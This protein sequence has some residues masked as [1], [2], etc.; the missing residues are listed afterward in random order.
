MIQLAIQDTSQASPL[1]TELLFVNADV[2]ESEILLADL[3]SW[4]EVIHLPGNCNGI[5]RITEVLA[6]HTGVAA[7]H[8]LG[9]GEKGQIE[10]GCTTLSLSSL[11]AACADISTWGRSLA[12]GAD[13]LFYGCDVGGSADGATLIAQL[14]YLTGANVAASTDLTGA[15]ALGG[16]WT[17]GVQT[18][19]IETVLPFSTAATAAW[20]HTLNHFRYGTMSWEPIA[21]SPN[22]VVIKGQVDWTND[23]GH[24]PLSTPIG[25]VVA[26]RLTLNFGDGTS[27]SVAVRVLSRDAVTDDVLTEFVS[28]LDGDGIIGASEVGIRHNYAATGN[29]EVFWGSAAREAARGQNSSTWQQDMRID[30]N[31]AGNQSPVVATPA[32]VQVVD[33]TTFT[34]QIAASDPDGNPLRFRYGTQDEFYNNN[35]ATEATRPT[36][37]TLSASGLITWDVHNTVL[38]TAT[39]DR[40]Q[41][42]IMAEDLDANGN[43]K[44]TV[45]VDFVLQIVQAG[46]QPPTFTQLPSGPQLATPG[47]TSTFT[48]EMDDPDSTEA[49]IITVL[50]P[51][52]TN[53]AVFQ[54]VSSVSPDGKTTLTISFTPT[55]DLGGNSYVVNIRGRDGTGLTTDQ[56]ITLTV[57]DTTPPSVSSSLTLAV[58]T[59]SGVIGDGTTNIATPTLVGTATAGNTVTLSDDTDGMPIVVGTAVADQT[60]HWSYT[61]TLPVADGTY[62][63]VATETLADGTVL[64]S[65]SPFALTIDT[66]A[67]A[68]P[69]LALAAASDSG[70]LGDDITNVTTPTISGPGEA[71]DTVTLFDGTT[72]VGAGI[73]GQ[74]GTWAITSGVLVPGA[75][76]FTA[77][78]SDVAGNGSTFSAALSVTIDTAPPATVSS[79]ALS[80]ATDSGTLGDRIT[81]VTTP[82]ITGSGGAGDTVTLYDNGTSIGTATVGAN[83]TWSVT[84][85]TLAGGV[86]TLTATETDYVGNVS[87]ASV[88]LGL[89]IDTAVPAAPTGLTLAPASD[90][91]ISGDDVTSML[92][93]TITG[94]AEGGST[95]VLSDAN[96]TLGTAVAG[97][98]GGWSIASS[99]LTAGVH[100]L[101]ATAADAA[102]NTSVVSAQLAL[103]VDVPSSPF[104]LALSAATDTGTLGDGITKNTKPTLTGS[105]DPN[106]TVTIT[107]TS[108]IASIVVGAV[109]ANASGSWSYTPT[110]PVANG[111]YSLTAT[112]TDAYGNV[113]AA[114]A[115]FA[116]TI[117]THKPAAPSGIRLV[118]PINGSGATTYTSVATPTLTGAGEA[119]ATITVTNNGSG[120]PVVLGTAVVNAS[121]AWTFT[122]TSPLADGPQSISTTATNAAGT[123]SAPSA[124]VAFTVAVAAP[125]VAAPTVDVA[126]AGAAA[127]ALGITRPTDPNFTADQ[128]TIA[129]SALPTNGTITLADG[130]TPVTLGE[131]LT[132]GQLTGLLFAGSAGMSGR[133][134]SFAYTVNDPAGNTTTGSVTLALSPSVPSFAAPAYFTNNASLAI[135]GTADAGTTVTLMEAGTAIGNGTVDSVTGAFSITP[136]TPLALGLSTL[137]STE[138]TIAGTSVASASLEVLNAGAPVNGVSIADFSSADVAAVL[139]HGA[140][141]AFIGGTEAI[142]LT[143]ST[144]SIGPNTNEATIQRFYKGL[145]GRSN[146]VGGMTDHDSLLSAGESKEVIAA[147]FLNGSEYL[148]SHG[149]QT[150]AQFVTSLYEGFLGRA[151]EEEGLSG[152]TTGL[153]TGASRAHVAIGIADASEAK[154]HLAGT[155]TRVWAVNPAGT[156]AHELYETGLA[157]EVELAA[158]PGFKAEYATSTPAQIADRIAA[159]PEFLAVHAGQSNV[160]LV[161]SLYQ[162]G[163]GRAPEADGAASWVGALNGGVSSGTVLLGIA[164]SAEAT[165]HLTHNIG[166]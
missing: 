4:I 96:G 39:G 66:T 121:G 2:P 130:V 59:D 77:I 27:E 65:S 156:L 107:R 3:G 151:P 44:S 42:T 13:I 122:P 88:P 22:S 104:G 127:I 138:T 125:V 147:S 69:L 93:P 17:L 58:S 94:T 54:T 15:A 163:L 32:V 131:T 31:Q 55:Q 162:S 89:T 144:L 90:T 41:V 10:L 57:P 143:D 97:Q 73:V 36:G 110:L 101:T 46:S 47:Q 160:A 137:T 166:L 145:L 83:G 91:G 116:L 75:H 18:G 128:L 109:T 108:G 78:Q 67:P 76:S 48:V 51:P 126:G 154:T 140:T 112:E 61:P 142:Q 63:L 114:S 20:Q 72:Q 71:G 30:L 9:H 37:L 62:K 8:I 38:S 148:A 146:D 123:V 6:D 150:D 102:G 100:H 85:G 16:N 56:S 117:D 81:N 87:A 74:D 21:G 164:T 129:V 70:T 28:D 82:V 14:A 111:T 68:A 135:T 133:N 43:V 1:A 49:P 5:A 86:H 98:S 53:P 158:L 132:A 26:N 119:G 115:P 149:T 7:L 99:A 79:L 12:E 120:S 152:W 11:H 118:S 161:A 141:F 92:T 165:A 84:S 113:S 80:P 50:N 124:A 105:A 136:T 34:Y 29:Y 64:P 134:S 155:T 106:A 95:V 33:D 23:H 35:V 153:A 45:P 25:G 159:S 52:S 157:R 40:W 103:T 24:I 60:G 139:N 19:Q